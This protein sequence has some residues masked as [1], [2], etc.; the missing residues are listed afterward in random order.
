MADPLATVADACN[1]KDG[2][3]DGRT[4]FV[5][6]QTVAGSLTKK[7]IETEFGGKKNKA[8]QYILKSGD[9]VPLWPLTQKDVFATK[10]ETSKKPLHGSKPAFPLKGKMIHIE[11]D[12]EEQGQP[13]KDQYKALCALYITACK[14]VGRILTIVPHIEVDRGIKNGHNDP[15]NFQYNDFYALL[16]AKG[17]DMKRVPRFS[18]DRYWGK[19]NFKTPFDTDTFSWPPKLSGDP[20]K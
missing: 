20:H 16:E 17:I 6:H 11:V 12:Y 14:E 3:C 5:V 4:H 10:S 9:V 19:P 8:H 18:H 2:S 1:K 13:N 15:Q 7:K